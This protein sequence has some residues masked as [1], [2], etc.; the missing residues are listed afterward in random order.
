MPRPSAPCSAKKEGLTHRLP[1]DREWSIAVGIGDQE[2][3][4]VATPES[5]SG[6]LKNVYPWGTSWPPAKAADNYADTDCKSQHPTEKI[7]EAYTDG[8]PI[9]SPVMSFPPNALAIHDL[10]GNVWEWCKDFYNTDNKDHFLR[11]ASWGSSAPQPLL[12]SFRGNQPST[13][14]WRCDGFRCVID[15]SAPV[16]A[17]HQ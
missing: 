5:L 1:T 12:L 14:R 8:F 11:G 2:A 10:G 9:K 17:S 4:T 3:S 15:E 7:I 13:R 16:K 6:K